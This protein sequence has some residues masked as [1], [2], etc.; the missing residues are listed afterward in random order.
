[1]DLNIASIIAELA[2]YAV[3]ISALVVGTILFLFAPFLL[4]SSGTGRDASLQVIFLRTATF[5]F[6][7][8]QLADIAI[9][10]TMAPYY[11]R[12]FLRASLTLFVI[13]LV[14]VAFNVLTHVLD[15]KFGNSRTLDGKTSS[16]PSYHSRMASMLLLLVLIIIL[17]YSFIEIWGI[18][19]L[20]QKTGFVGIVAAMMV[21]TSSTWMPDLFYGLVLLNSSMADEGDTIAIP[22]EDRIYIINRLTPFYTLLLDVDNN[23][24]V[25][26]RNSQ[27]VQNKVENLSKRASVEGLRRKMEFKLG[28]PKDNLDGDGHSRLF[29]RVD[30]AVLGA[31]ERVCADPN[32]QVNSKIPF[33]WSLVEAGDN[34]LRFIMYYH[35]NALPDTK[36]TNKIRAHVRATNNA[37]V[38]F[39][40]E[41]AS[42]EGLD[43][44][45]PSLLKIDAGNLAMMSSVDHSIIDK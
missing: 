24:R 17:I 42:V 11:N 12:L 39:V 7:V 19:S 27:M 45:T 2:V 34:A 43:L 21:L 15:T 13:I 4:R 18:D 3:P 9:H 25:M 1:M 10:Q 37:I 29:S 16:V 5:G 8:L 6:I 23:H 30:K 38:R 20:L 35:L 22:G 40:F 28:Y 33:E 44:S 26:M 41:E 32:V 14:L 31:F 36:L